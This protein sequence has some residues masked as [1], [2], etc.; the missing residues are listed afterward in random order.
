MALAVDARMKGTGPENIRKAEIE[1]V[2]LSEHEVA[3]HSLSKPLCI[4]ASNLVKGTMCQEK[5]VCVCTRPEVLLFQKNLI[6]CLKHFFPAPKKSDKDAGIKSPELIKRQ[7]LQDGLFVLRFQS[8]PSADE[9]ASC[10]LFVHLGYINYSSWDFACLK[11]NLWGEQTR[12]D[13]LRL[14][15]LRNP[16]D[17]LFLRRINREECVVFQILIEP[18]LQ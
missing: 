6:L 4:N 10:D 3:T 14:S 9:V 1:R 13:E 16:E 12:A 15:T 18:L 8:K 2:W 7:Q 17:E 5:G 11:L